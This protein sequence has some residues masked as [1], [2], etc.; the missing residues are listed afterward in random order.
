MP[1]E[2]IIDSYSTSSNSKTI[3]ELEKEIKDLE[4]PEQDKGE[5]SKPGDEDNPPEESK[6]EGDAPPKEKDPT[7]EG[8]GDKQDGLSPEEE[9]FKKRYG[10]SRRFIQ[11]LQD[12]IKNLKSEGNSINSPP[13]SE[14]DLAQWAS[15]NPEIASIVETIAAKKAEEKFSTTKEQLKS[16]D[17]ERFELRR[18]K[19]ENQIRK[20]HPDY[21]EIKV[22]DKFHTWASE[23]PQVLQDAL[24]ENPDDWESVAKVI[25]IYKAEHGLTAEAEKEKSKLA[26]MDTQVKGDSKPTGKKNTT[27]S[28]SKVEKLSIKDYVKYE[29]DIDKAMASGDFVYDITGR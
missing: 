4:N 18:E 20:Q 28:E 15:E 3:E 6:T 17:E 12:Q 16:I 22:D 8:E 5:G 21:D 10:D 27:W 13:T 2:A 29:D 14:E 9:T 23:Q 25:G 11:K 1:K 26:A 19:G 24:Y 7:P